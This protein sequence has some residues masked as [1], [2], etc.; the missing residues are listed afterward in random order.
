MLRKM[1]LDEYKT[2]ISYASIIFVRPEGNDLSKQIQITG[3][4]IQNLIP[5][6]TKRCI[7]LV[8]CIKDLLLRIRFTKYRTFFFLCSMAVVHPSDYEIY[9]NTRLLAENCPIESITIGVM[10]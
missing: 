1:R 5:P 9:K 4:Q 3:K 2:K 6:V 7:I 10:P 8:L